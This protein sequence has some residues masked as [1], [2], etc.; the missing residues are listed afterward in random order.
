MTAGAAPAGDAPTAAVSIRPMRW[1]DIE[2]VMVLERELFVEDSWS[3]ELFWAELAE[4]DSRHYLVADA[5]GGLA[6]YAGLLAYADEGYVQ[7]IAVAPPYQ[8]CGIGARLL[9]ALMD[10]ARRVGVPSVGLE[11][12]SDNERA[13]R[14]YRRFGFRSVGV[15]RGYYQPSGADAVVMFA[16]DVDGT[17]YGELLDRL[18]TVVG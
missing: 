11:V 15:R 10:E 9:T 12:R 3:A 7:T 4:H 14:L 8:G 1:W 13:Q 17:A 2:P 16:R 5:D 18:R 6:G